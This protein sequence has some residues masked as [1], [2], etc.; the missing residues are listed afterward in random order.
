MDR[1]GHGAFGRAFYAAFPDIRHDIEDV[2]ATEDRVALRFVLRGTHSADFYGIPAT[3]RRIEVAAHILLQVV[4][5]QVVTL[6]GVFDEAGM[7]RQLGV[8]PGG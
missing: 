7:L 6:K 8:L 4:D 5:G 2:F 3:R 1:A